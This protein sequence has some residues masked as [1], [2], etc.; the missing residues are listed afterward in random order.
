MGRLFGVRRLIA[1]FAG[2]KAA[3]KRRTP[4][5]PRIRCRFSSADLLWDRGG[6]LQIG[7]LLPADCKSAATIRFLS[8]AAQRPG[9]IL[10]P[11]PGSL[12]PNARWYSPPMAS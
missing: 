7:R 4:K 5:Q 8:A 2:R 10:G 1:A 11:L 6:R 3:L 12:L 9:G